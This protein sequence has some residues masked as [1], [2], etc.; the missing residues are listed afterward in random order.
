[1]KRI[2]RGALRLGSVCRVRQEL[3]KELRLEYKLDVGLSAYNSNTRPDDTGAARA[4]I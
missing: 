3:R 2:E 4:L 1:M